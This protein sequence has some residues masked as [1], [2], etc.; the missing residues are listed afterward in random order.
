MVGDGVNDAL[1]LA[2]ADLGLAVGS[3]ADVAIGAADMVLLRDRLDVVPAALGLARA[4]RRTVRRN[5]A[6]AFAY[7]VAA[8]PL[9]AAGLLSPLVA[10]AAM[11]T[12]SAFVVASSLRLG[13]WSPGGVSSSSR[14]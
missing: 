11:A 14:S 6:W 8:L 13:R 2:R 12:S 5:L 10:G 9:A 3:G 7:N 1:A 4:T